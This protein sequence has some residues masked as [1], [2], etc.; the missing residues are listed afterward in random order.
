MRRRTWHTGLGL[1]ALLIAGAA[2][3]PTQQDFCS[4]PASCYTPARGPNCPQVRF[5]WG[6]CPG[7]RQAC[8]WCY[9]P[10]GVFAYAPRGSTYTLGSGCNQLGSNATWATKNPQIAQSMTKAGGNCASD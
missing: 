3:S 1:V 9:G 8:D 6:D 2:Q 5:G 10:D 7:S 4:S